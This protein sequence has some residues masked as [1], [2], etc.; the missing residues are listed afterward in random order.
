MAKLSTNYMGLKLQN[1]LIVSSSSLT[2]KLD[3]LK[4]CEENGAGAVV[5]KSLFEEQIEAEI[6]ELEKQSDIFSHP[7]AMDYIRQTSINM[8]PEKYIKLI[9][10][11]KQTLTIPV[12][13]SLNAITA[14]GWTNFTKEIEKAGADAIELNIAIMPSSVHQRTEEIENT[15]IGIVENLKKSTSLPIAVKLGPYFSALPNFINRISDVGVKAIV[16]FNRFYQLD[17]DIEKLQL[18]A[19]YKFSNPSE[20]HTPLRWIAV[21]YGQVE[22]QLSATTGIH[23]GEGFIKML[24]AGATTVQ[25]C[26]TLYMNKIEK[27][28]E[29]LNKLTEWMESKG[30]STIE[31]FRGLLSMTKSKQP[32]SYERLQYIKALVGIE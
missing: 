27:I 26:S 24:L 1:P 30:Y 11:A 10:N 12:I 18:K 20:I 29:I 5:L 6:K 2:Q 13:A 8:G 14:K 15:Y 7:E 28:R 19:G 21:M 25:V 16:L 23:D 22:A 3:T 4:K 32:E 9:E 31:D 17:I